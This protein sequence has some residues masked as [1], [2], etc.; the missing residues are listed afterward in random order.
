MTEDAKSA[1]PRGAALAARNKQIV[2]N[3][4]DALRRQDRAAIDAALSQNFR[5]LRLKDRMSRFEYLDSLERTVLTANKPRLEMAFIATSGDSVSIEIALEFDFSGRRLKGLYN[6]IYVIEDGE[7]YE[8]RE[9][10]GIP[11]L[12]A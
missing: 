9:Y 12:S 7:L 2:L 4:I 8:M 5:Y 10:G 3:Y 11:D 1:G 6:T